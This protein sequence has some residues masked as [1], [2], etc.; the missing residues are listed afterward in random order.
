MIFLF[1]MNSN[2][3]TKMETTLQAEPTQ[4]FS[5]IFPS[6]ASD[7]TTQHSPSQ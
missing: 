6:C 4:S 7:L 5:S 2:F 3:S 1:R